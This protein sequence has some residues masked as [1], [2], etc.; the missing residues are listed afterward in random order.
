MW[1]KHFFFFFAAQGKLPSAFEC[2]NPTQSDLVQNIY[3]SKSCENQK[4][5]GLGLLGIEQNNIWVKKKKKSQP[6]G[7]PW[8]GL[9]SRLSTLRHQILSIF[10]RREQCSTLS[11]HI[12]DASVRLC[13]DAMGLMLTHT[14]NIHEKSTH[15]GD[16]H[17]WGRAK[18][19]HLHT[20]QLERI[21]VRQ[22]DIRNMAA[23]PR[24]AWA[25]AASA[26]QNLKN[27][28]GPLMSEAIGQYYAWWLWVLQWTLSDFTLHSCLF[29]LTAG[30]C[31]AVDTVS[32]C[33]WGFSVLENKFFWGGGNVW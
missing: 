28:R 24:S 13:V 6:S 14:K 11:Q 4:E 26:R 16:V 12:R 20:H 5:E 10:V 19:I 3:N 22:C 9:G 27:A 8:Q 31:S 32:F 1:Q 2:C 15:S 7:T 17:S 23:F 25:C 29:V 30:I 18:N 21:P 33:F